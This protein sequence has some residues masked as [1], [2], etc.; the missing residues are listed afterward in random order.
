MSGSRRTVTKLVHALHEGRL[1]DRGRREL[2]RRVLSD[3][4]ALRAYLDLT[5]VH[6]HLLH[7]AGRL[8]EAAGEPISKTVAPARPRTARRAYH[9]LG[10]AASLALLAGL[11]FVFRP[12][13]P[14]GEP[15]ERRDEV[16]ETGVLSTE[17]VHAPMPP[18]PTPELFAEDRPVLTAAKPQAGS[19]T[20]PPADADEVVAFVD[21]RLA[22]GWA[23]A[24]TPPSPEAAPG[25][26]LRRVWLDLA[27]HIPTVADVRRFLADDRPD[28][29]AR[30][31]GRLLDS[32]AFAAHLAERWTTALVGRAPRDG[33]DRA[34]LRSH[35]AAAFDAGRGWDET[36]AELVAAAG[37]ADEEPAAN[38]LLAHV[39]NAA[40]PATAVTA[41]ALLGTRI[42]CMQCHDHP[43]NGGAEWS[44]ERFWQLNAFFKGTSVSRDRGVAALEVKSAA[45]PTFYE[46]RRGVM[47]ATFPGYR[48]E[49][50]EGEPDRRRKLAELLLTDDRRLV[51]RSF[52]NRAW[53]HLFGAGLVNPV[54]DLGPHNPPSHPE[55]LD[56]L[57]DRFVA[58]GYDVRDLYRVLASSRLYALGSAATDRNADDDP[59]RGDAPL[60]TRCYPK[61]LSAEQTFDS[62]AVARGESPDPAAR[63]GWVARFVRRVETDENG[64]TLPGATDIP[65]ALALM[66]EREAA[67]AADD[68]DGVFLATLAR[69]PTR[70]ER[71]ALGRLVARPGG[72][73]DLRWAL[74]NSGEFATV[75]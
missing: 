70:R 44:Q 30:E 66:N 50:F 48:G 43:T 15:E 12:V 29:R 45:G 25:E 58:T 14:A 8:P 36:A 52:V 22:A 21:A 68:L 33:V 60:F 42:Q 2:E 55:V 38:F 6:G 49:T 62:L 69:T 34:G 37:P 32:E 47:R 73:D 9:V 71:A 3:P 53:A 26:W 74:L 18:V 31:V 75:P 4:A 63:D 19:A 54:D 41:R 27:G 5:A 40:V 24:E 46:T 1:D 17:S 65:R 11:A 59:G 51:A 57:A 16:A 61:P 10:L 56:R 35:L 28:R 39:N 64:E 72:L 20:D 23:D 13:P 7:D 67:V